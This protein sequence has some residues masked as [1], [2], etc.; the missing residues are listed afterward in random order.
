M[1]NGMENTNVFHTIFR[2]DYIV[3]KYSISIYIELFS[4][5]SLLAVPPEDAASEVTG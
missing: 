5:E 4:A 2:I 1:K 3:I